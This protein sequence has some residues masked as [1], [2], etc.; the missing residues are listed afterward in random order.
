M[1]SVSRLADFEHFGLLSGLLDIPLTKSVGSCHTPSDDPPMPLTNFFFD[2]L[3]LSK[4]FY[5]HIVDLLHP[6]CSSGNSSCPSRYLYI[7]S[8]NMPVS[9]FHAR[10]R[11]VMGR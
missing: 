6:F 9:N 7:S 5:L 8:E 3:L 1:I 10:G 11:H 4:S 2:V